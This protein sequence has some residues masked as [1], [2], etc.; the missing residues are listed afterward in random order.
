MFCLHFEVFQS[1]VELFVFITLF[2]LFECLDAHLLL[3]QA[4]LNLLH[5]RVS[6]EHLCKEVIRS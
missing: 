5:V 3:E 2:L 6:L 1:L 4:T